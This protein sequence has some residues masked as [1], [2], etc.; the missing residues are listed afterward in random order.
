VE[1]VIAAD[2]LLLKERG[3]IASDRCR[4]PHFHLDELTRRRIL[5]AFRAI[6]DLLAG[7]V[8]KCL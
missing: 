8:L 7:D 4:A 5:S 3:I 6:E 2:K 1:M